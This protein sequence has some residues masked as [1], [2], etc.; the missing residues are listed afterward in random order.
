MQTRM[1]QD[2]P[3]S[4]PP[5]EYFYVLADVLVDGQVVS[6]DVVLDINKLADIAW[7]Q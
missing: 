5:E 4:L 7:K 1:P 2:A 6:A 3:G